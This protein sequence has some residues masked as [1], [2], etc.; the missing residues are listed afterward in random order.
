MI[1]RKPERTVEGKIRVSVNVVGKG[2]F[3]GIG[4]NHRIAK[5]AAAK[6]ALKVI[7]ECHAEEQK[8][9]VRSQQLYES[10]FVD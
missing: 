9:Q 2:V 10:L 4:R 6:R 8:L 5:S 3:K 1:D 7:R